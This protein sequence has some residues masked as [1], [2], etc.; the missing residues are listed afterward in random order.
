MRLFLSFCL[1]LV[2]SSSDF[3][4]GNRSLEDEFLGLPNATNETP[5]RQARAAIS[6]ALTTDILSD[7]EGRVPKEFEVTPFWSPFVRFWFGIYTRYSTH[8][9]VIHDKVD[10]GVVYGVLDFSRVVGPNINRFARSA[11]VQEISREK[12]L[13]VKKVLTDLS[14]GEAHS[15]M[16]LSVLK[17]LHDSGQP[18]PSD[19]SA[20]KKY[21]AAK[22]LNIRTQT[23]QRDL[24][25]AGIA[26]MAP[27]APFFRQLFDGF[28][29]PRELLAIPFLESSFN[30]AAHS[31]VGALGIWQFMPLISSYFV[32]KRNDNVDYRL[33]P[34]IAS[35]SALHLLRENKKILR[36]WDLAVTAY[37][38]GTKHLVKARRE[39]GASGLEDILKRYNHPHLGFASKNFYAEFIALVHTIA[40]RNE[41]FP[42]EK[43]ISAYDPRQLH[44]AIARCSFIPEKIKSR[45]WATLNPHLRSPSRT[46]PRGT[47]VVNSDSRDKR[48]LNLTTAQISQIRP[49]D[50]QKKWLGNQ[51]CSTR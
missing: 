32:P 20:R 51:S 41:I 31:K 15:R 39:L 24:I 44:L 28:D 38:S 42:A 25:E 35:A 16:A 29:L 50:W 49:I 11:I 40:Y 21:F 48:F 19:A 23:G 12:M 37:N 33:N 13:E 5:I 9:I 22:A 26:N 2:L 4:H 46:Y 18:P 30:N 7:F 47:L 6:D 3:L 17:A 14:T 34:L 1:L 45:D 8:H 27:Y 10:L 43:D 36:S